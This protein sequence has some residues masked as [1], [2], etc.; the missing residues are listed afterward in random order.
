MLLGFVQC[1]SR[2]F[3]KSLFVTIVA[4]YIFRS[5]R[6]FSLL[7]TLTY[8]DLY[9]TINYF[10]NKMTKKFEVVQFLLVFQYETTLM[11]SILTH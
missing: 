2:Y 10:M 1:N 4:K 8:K 9:N 7:Y 5:T 6:S 11:V 3:L